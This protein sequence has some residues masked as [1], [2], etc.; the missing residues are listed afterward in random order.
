MK[1]DS[2]AGVRNVMV[3]GCRPRP[4]VRQMAIVK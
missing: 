4:C 1:L 2:L 3:A